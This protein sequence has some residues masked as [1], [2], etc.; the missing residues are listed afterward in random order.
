M[1][2]EYLEQN[3]GDATNPSDL[4]GG[5]TDAQLCSEC[6]VNLFKYQQST[7]YS[8][9]DPDMASAWASIQKKCSLSLPT[10]TQTLKTNVT[11]LGNYAPAGYAT[12]ACVAGRN[13][14][15]VGGDNC[16]DISKRYNV[17]TG[18]LIS[19]NSLRMDCTNIFVG[20]VSDSSEASK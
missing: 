10:A 15:V 6:I 4:L 8:N 16:I 3:I 1:L 14:T 20:Q 19:V 5:Y 2:A 13:Y 17:S 9:Y 11:S 12:S 18:A 7:S